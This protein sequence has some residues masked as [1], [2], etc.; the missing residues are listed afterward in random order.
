MD[1]ALILVAAGNEGGHAQAGAG[2]DDGFITTGDM[3]GDASIGSPAVAKNCLTVGA[4]ETLAE[5][6][7]VASFSSRGPTPDMRL[8]P[9]V[10]GPG[11]A[12]YSLQASGSIGLASCAVLAMSGTSMATPAVAGA[13]A[14]L[15]QYLIDGKHAVYSSAGAAGSSYNSANPSGALI[16]ALLIGS[17]APLPNG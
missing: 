11:D 14:V 10:C 1:D 4:A 16:K 3:G 15:R 8:K 2:D 13:A 5:P 9:E 12:D 17:T 7:T 6:T